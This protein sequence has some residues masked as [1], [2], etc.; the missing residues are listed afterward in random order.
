MVGKLDRQPQPVQYGIALAQDTTISDEQLLQEI[1]ANELR[2][3]IPL[4]ESSLIPTAEAFLDGELISWGSARGP[5]DVAREALNPTSTPFRFLATLARNPSEAGERAVAQLATHYDALPTDAHGIFSNGEEQA[6]FLK[7]IMV[8]G[9]LEQIEDPQEDYHNNSDSLVK[10]IAGKSDQFLASL[11]RLSPDDYAGV[12]R[13]QEVIV[14]IIDEQNAVI[15]KHKK[16]A[17]RVV[18]QIPAGKTMLERTLRVT[19]G[20]DDFT[21]RFMKDLATAQGNISQGWDL[22]TTYTAVDALAHTTTD[23]LRE[24]IIA[25]ID[26]NVAKRTNGMVFGGDTLP[27][28]GPAYA[29]LLRFTWADDAAAY[30]EE[31]HDSM[32]EL[33]SLFDENVAHGSIEFPTG[34]VPAPDVPSAAISLLLRTLEGTAPE[35]RKELLELFHARFGPQNKDA[36]CVALLAVQTAFPDLTEDIQERVENWKKLAPAISSILSEREAGTVFLVGKQLTGVRSDRHVAHG[37]PLYHSQGLRRLLPTEPE[38][39]YKEEETPPARSKIIP[40]EPIRVESFKA[41]NKGLYEQ[42]V[43]ARDA[44]EILRSLFSP[45]QV[46]ED[47]WVVLDSLLREQQSR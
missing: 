13:L 23:H 19:M 4:P 35:K 39:T 34:S 20:E 26:A 25:A 11:A 32:P 22:H 21:D 33:T 40:H 30:V 27:L 8:Q 24:D 28:P 10:I 31:V 44:T 1:Y 47:E 7:L 14:R 6:W 15:A 38:K 18:N 45:R 43:A 46:S 12:I 2:N 41:L 9:V 3:M 17:I 29:D 37:I 36:W 42:A 16:Q 5:H